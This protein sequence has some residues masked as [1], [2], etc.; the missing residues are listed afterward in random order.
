M[1]VLATMAVVVL[2]GLFLAH[3][4]FLHLKAA[5][6]EHGISIGALTVG[7]PT[8]IEETSSRVGLGDGDYR[9]PFGDSHN[10]HDVHKHD[11]YKTGPAAADIK[12]DYDADAQVPEKLQPSKPLFGSEDART[13]TLK[14]TATFSAPHV[15]Q[16]P[17]DMFSPPQPAQH[18]LAPTDSRDSEWTSA[19][20]QEVK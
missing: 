5:S 12:V 8:W 13:P 20:D 4:L 3:R 18:S 15:K 2:L 19:S 7:I 9:P 16:E 14:S 6:V 11:V 10:A 1:G 17:H